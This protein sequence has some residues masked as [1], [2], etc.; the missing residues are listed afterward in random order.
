MLAAAGAAFLGG[1]PV[2]GVIDGGMIVAGMSTAFSGSAIFQRGHSGGA[3]DLN[4]RAGPS[5]V[6]RADYVRAWTCGT[7]S[8]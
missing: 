6:S 7:T 4:N 2:Q 3:F 1:K 8:G 5:A